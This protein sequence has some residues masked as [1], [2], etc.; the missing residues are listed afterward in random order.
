MKNIFLVASALFGLT[1]GFICHRPTQP[2]INWHT[3]KK[4]SS[5]VITKKTIKPV[6][7]PNPIIDTMFSLV[8]PINS[9]I[10]NCHVYVFFSFRR[11][12]IDSLW[13]TPDLPDDSSTYIKIEKVVDYKSIKPT[14]LELKKEGVKIIKQHKQLNSLNN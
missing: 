11:K 14:L 8:T 7:P 13:K 5:Y 6:V 9:N 2:I 3:I 1:I 10:Y 4:I 12:Y